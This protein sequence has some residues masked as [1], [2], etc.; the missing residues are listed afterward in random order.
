MGQRYGSGSSTTADSTDSTDSTVAQ[1][2]QE[3]ASEP[4]VVSV[5]KVSIVEVKP[6][7]V[8][9][10]TETINENKKIVVTESELNKLL[11]KGVKIKNIKKK[12]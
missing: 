1:D 3:P 8:V 9:P 5:E 4:V 11:E 7:A 2:A 10:A 12:S 6:V